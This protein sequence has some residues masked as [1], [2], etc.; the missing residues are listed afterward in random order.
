MGS[1]RQYGHIAKILYRLMAMKLYPD[2]YKFA[3]GEIDVLN[4]AASI[5]QEISPISIAELNYN[6]IKNWTIKRLREHIITDWNALLTAYR[7]EFMLYG[8][9]P[10]IRRIIEKL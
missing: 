4:Y 10:A 5:G 7:L 9:N 8:D 1:S 2:K 3:E 6:E